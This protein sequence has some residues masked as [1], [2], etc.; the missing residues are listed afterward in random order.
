MTAAQKGVTPEML[1]E[2][3]STLA[4]KFERIADILTDAMPDPEKIQRATLQ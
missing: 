2:K 3:A 4:D 1:E